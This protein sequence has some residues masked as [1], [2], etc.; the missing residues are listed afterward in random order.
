MFKWIK[1]YREASKPMKG[2]YITLWVYMLAII[3]TTVFVY[4]RL[5]Y[6]RSYPMKKSEQS[7]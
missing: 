4:A 6:V 2:F 5:D 1:A 7:K 3:I